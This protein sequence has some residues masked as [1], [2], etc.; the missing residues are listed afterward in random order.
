MNYFIQ[1]SFCQS[2]LLYPWTGYHSEFSNCHLCRAVIISITKLVCKQ[3]CVYRK[4]TASFVSVSVDNVWLC[5]VTLS[6][7]AK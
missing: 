3:F 6:W 5:D 1:T 2:A 4:L 7:K